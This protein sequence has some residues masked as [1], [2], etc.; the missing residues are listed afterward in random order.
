MKRSKSL[1]GHINLAL[2]CRVG[3]KCG[4]AHKENNITHD[5]VV[6]CRRR[7]NSTMWSNVIQVSQ[8][9]SEAIKLVQ[10]EQTKGVT[11]RSVASLG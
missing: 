7:H 3:D 11:G 5:M 6:Y 1:V 10:M 8:R 4:C 2:M 9:G